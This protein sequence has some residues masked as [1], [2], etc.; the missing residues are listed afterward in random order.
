MLFQEGSWFGAGAA[1]FAV[2]NPHRRKQSIHGGWRDVYQGLD[3]L[4]WEWTEMLNVSGKPEGQ[5]GFE[6]F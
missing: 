5:E 6:A 1:L 2:L 3:G 4:G